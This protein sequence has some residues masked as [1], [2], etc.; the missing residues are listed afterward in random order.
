M[1]RVLSSAI[2]VAAAVM[3]AA[4]AEIITEAPPGH[5]VE[6]YTDMQNFDNTFGFMGDYHSTRKLVFTDD[7]SVYIPNLLMSRTMPAYLKG[8]Y[9]S[10]AK[11]ITVP[12]GQCVFVFPNIKVPV[13]FFALDADGQAGPSENEFY[14]EPLVFDIA[15]DGVISLRASEEFPLFGIGSTQNSTE[16]YSLAKDLRFI[17]VENISD[18]LQ[19]FTSTY[20][21]GEDTNTTTAAAY[22]EGNDIIWVQGL[23]PKYPTSWI[24]VQRFSETEWIIPSFQVMYYFST[25][26]PIVA[27]ALNKSSGD[28]MFQ[29]IVSVD[30]ETLEMSIGNPTVVLG[31]ITPDN[32]GSFNVYQQYDNIHLEPG[33]FTASKPAAPSFF[34]YRESTGKTEFV[35]TADDKDV[36]GEQLINTQ[37]FFRMY[38]DGEPYTFTTEKY[39]WI[40]EDMA[41]V[42]FNFDNYYFFSKGRNKR[43]VYF[44]QLPADTKTIGVEI[45]YNMGGAEQTSD[46]LVYDIASQ[47][48]EVV[49]GIEDVAVDS[50][51]PAVFYDMQGIRTDNPEPGRL[52]IRVRGNKA[53]KVLVK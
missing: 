29:M 23:D 49:L 38:V 28:A 17:P 53:E 36:N 41:L 25:E 48:A 43:Y 30:E 42:P 37:L 12:N 40:D 39:K 4:A 44:Q 11:T 47:K 21:Q 32:N 35:F 31:N 18:K 34:G 27:A 33:N 5:S 45:I 16:V 1:N 26:D 14:T 2:M 6:Y 22:R 10:G 8:T 20:V 51:A 52:Y 19:H 7:G 3:P 24:K 15:D 50:D 13:G 9:D 46:R